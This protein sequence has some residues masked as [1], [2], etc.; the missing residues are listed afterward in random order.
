MLQAPRAANSSSTKQSSLRRKVSEHRRTPMPELQLV[1]Q[2][3]EQLEA[4]R[5]V[6]ARP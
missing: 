6:S 5:S 2:D 3:F 4:N 1:R